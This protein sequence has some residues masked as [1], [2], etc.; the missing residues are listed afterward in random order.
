MQ[1]AMARQAEAERERRAKVIHAEGERQAAST[2]SE[3][4]GIISQ[5]PA[6]IQ[7]RYLQT[8]G[9][10]GSEQNSTI[11][12][13]L[14]MDLIQPLISAAEAVTPQ[15]EPAQHNGELPEAAGTAELPRGADA[16]AVEAARSRGR[17][18]S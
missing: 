6:A 18:V 2:L 1:R 17:A 3:A 11:V 5:Q 13:P 4:A 9:E 16:P 8:L 10:I 7:L 15:A 14:P 12:F